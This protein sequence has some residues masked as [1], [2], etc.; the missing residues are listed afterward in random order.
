MNTIVAEDVFAVV[1][2]EVGLQRFLDK[3]FILLLLCKTMFGLMVAVRI[4]NGE[5]QTVD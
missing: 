5:D 3:A 2:F 4:S 1:A